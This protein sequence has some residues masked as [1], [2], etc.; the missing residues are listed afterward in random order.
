M[1][2]TPAILRGDRARHLDFDAA[3]HPIALQLG[4]D[5]PADLAECARMAADWGYDEVNINVGCP[6]DRV[7]SGCFG[8]S[9][10]KRPEVV[11]RA[12]E[13]MRAAV[14]LPVTVKHRIGVD[15]LDRYEDM[16]HFVDVV[17]QA[18][19]DRFSV[20]ARKAWLQGLSPKE[21]RTVPPLRY[22]DV[23]RL[24]RDRPDLVVEIN[25]GVVDLAATEAHLAQVDA[26]MVGRAAYDTP[27]EFAQVDS[28]V[29]GAEDPGLS[30]ADVVEAMLPYME[31]HVASGRR[32]HQVSRHLIG[33]FNGEPGA[34]Q[35]R[36]HLST[37]APRPDA[38]VAVVTDALALVAAKYRAPTDSLVQ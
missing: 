7:Q 32:I 10:M 4:G 35:W 23:Y 27:F 12:V 31:R 19:A 24:K 15:E 20:H 3:E 37:Y 36:R 26:V 14:D 6:S 21:N 11:A 30:R 22:E 28:R 17:A 29:F 25:G 5:D 8:A 38:S 13:A 2:T 34:R 16:L 33:L 1:V 18:G 9:L